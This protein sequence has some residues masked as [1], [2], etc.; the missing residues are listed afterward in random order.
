MFSV[1]DPRLPIG[2]FVD[3]KMGAR[4][5]QLVTGQFPRSGLVLLAPGMHLFVPQKCLFFIHSGCI[6]L[7]NIRPQCSVER[8]GPWFKKYLEFQHGGRIQ[9]SLAG[10]CA[11]RVPW[12]Y[13]GRV[14]GRPAPVTFSMFKKWVWNASLWIWKELNKRV[15]L[16]WWEE[17]SPALNIS[18]IPVGAGGRWVESPLQCVL[19]NGQSRKA[20][21][22]GLITKLNNWGGRRETPL[23]V[24]L[25]PPQSSP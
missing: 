5:V 7:H 23:F 13:M 1:R 10:P 25:F 18:L 17:K 8:Q 16:R 22:R 19:L 9:L 20:T 14:P 6:Q 11:H 2:I 12:D 15:I 4:L 24:P 21:L 3:E